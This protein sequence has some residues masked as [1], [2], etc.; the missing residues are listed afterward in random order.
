M[1]RK[2]EGGREGKREGRREG[3]TERVVSQVGAREGGRERVIN[4]CHSTL[5][6]KSTPTMI[7]QR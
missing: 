1:E 5:Y 3:L 6:C 7:R 2:G 4:A